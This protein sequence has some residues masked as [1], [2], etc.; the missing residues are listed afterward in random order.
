MVFM[1][2]YILK[3]SLS[4]ARFF[5]TASCCIGIAVS[6]LAQGNL[7]INGGFETPL[8]PTNNFSTFTAP[9]NFAGWTVE[10]GGVDVVNT[11]YFQSASGLQSLDLNAVDAG[12]VYQDIVT[13]SNVSYRLSFAFGANTAYPSF[14]PAVKIME[15]DWNTNVLAVLDYDVTGSQ[16]RSRAVARVFLHGVGHRP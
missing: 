11:N 2:R 8:V 3:S 1:R 15:V 6:T 10:F 4:S 13:L 5:L 16:N 14:P 7:V 12:A 9:T